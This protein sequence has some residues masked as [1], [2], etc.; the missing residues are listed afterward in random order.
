MALV[1]TPIEKR[2]ERIKTSKPKAKKKEY[3]STRLPVGL[4]KTVRVYC[5]KHDLTLEDFI[6]E[7]VIDRLSKSVK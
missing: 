3:F 5:A 7:A 4:K 6:E 1:D 2:F